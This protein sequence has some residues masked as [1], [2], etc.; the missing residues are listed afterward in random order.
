MTSAADQ[1]RAYA[2]SRATLDGRMAWYARDA[3]RRG[4]HFRLDPA[5]FAVLEADACLYCGVRRKLHGGIDR[6]DNRRGYEPD[7]VVPCCG[8]CNRRKRD[9]PVGRFLFGW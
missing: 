7:N 6:V 4:L 9:R 2:E 3:R 5:L 1:R 8:P